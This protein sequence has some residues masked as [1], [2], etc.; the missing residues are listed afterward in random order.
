[1]PKKLYCPLC[2]D[3]DLIDVVA[4]S[5]LLLEQSKPERGMIF[6]APCG[7][8]VHGYGKTIIGARRRARKYWRLLCTAIEEEKKDESN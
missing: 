1:M 7:I 2:G 5:S 6:C 4:H 8:E 3:T